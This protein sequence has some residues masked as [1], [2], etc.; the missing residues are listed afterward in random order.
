MSKL[1]AVNIIINSSYV[2]IIPLL[3]MNSEIVDCTLSSDLYNILYVNIEIIS[4]YLLIDNKNLIQY[5]WIV[6]HIGK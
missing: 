4:E 1:Q 3:S 5:I 2:L 6:N